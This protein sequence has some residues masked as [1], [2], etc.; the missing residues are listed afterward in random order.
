MIGSSWRCCYE[1]ADELELGS[2]CVSGAKSINIS[3][4]ASPSDVCVCV[5]W[6]VPNLKGYTVMGNTLC[7]EQNRSVASYWPGTCPFEMRGGWFVVNHLGGILG[8][9]LLFWYWQCNSRSLALE[10]KLD[11]FGVV[12]YFASKIS[13]DSFRSS[14]C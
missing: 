1:E 14:F 9:C 5:V 12:P 7:F 4:E 6:G 8:G 2:L 11:I 3:R 10:W 13:I